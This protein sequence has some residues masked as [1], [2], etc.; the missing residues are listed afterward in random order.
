M[1]NGEYVEET[2]YIDSESNQFQITIPEVTR[3]EI[4]KS[5][6]IPD[7]TEITLFFMGIMVSALLGWIIGLSV[8]NPAFM[9]FSGIVLL[10]FYCMRWAY[11]GPG[12][13]AARIRMLEQKV[14]QDQSFDL[15]FNFSGFIVSIVFII[16]GSIIS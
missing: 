1:S 13:F 14:A 10:T 7:S 9:I 3:K 6:L 15:D 12:H 5:L 4:V 16:V 11:F 8:L 2:I